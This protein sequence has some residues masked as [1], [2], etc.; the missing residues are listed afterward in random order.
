MGARGGL[1]LLP[2]RKSDPRMSRH[3]A[4]AQAIRIRPLTVL[5]NGHVTHGPEP[6]RVPGGLQWVQ[7]GGAAAMTDQTPW[8]SRSNELVSIE[9]LESARDENNMAKSEQILAELLVKLRARIVRARL[10]THGKRLGR[11]VT[12]LGGVRT[13]T[14]SG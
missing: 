10:Y 5:R 3:A 8:S 1:A 9:I 7:G 6:M 13:G 11:G 4:R 2:P 14:T 12:T